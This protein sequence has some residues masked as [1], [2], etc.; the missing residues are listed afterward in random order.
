MLYEV[1]TCAL[2]RANGL[3]VFTINGFPYGTFHG[4]R[5]KED[6][7]LPDWLDDERL[8]YTNVLAGLL[9]ALLPDDSALEG[10]VSTVP[11]AFKP[12]APSRITSYNVCYTKLLRDDAEARRSPISRPPRGFS[13]P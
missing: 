2:L 6:V 5:V 1:I 13:A 12:R 8:R 9:A 11:G 4:K 7:Y 3:Y 10:S